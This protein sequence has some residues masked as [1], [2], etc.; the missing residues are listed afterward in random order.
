MSK[1]KFTTVSGG[2]KTFKTVRLIMKMTAFGKV[3]EINTSGG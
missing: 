1:K 2:D 3:N